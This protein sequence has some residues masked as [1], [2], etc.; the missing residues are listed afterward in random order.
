MLEVSY[1]KGDLEVVCNVNINLLFYKKLKFFDDW[2][3]IKLI[4][5]IC[6]LVYMFI[7]IEYMLKLVYVYVSL[8]FW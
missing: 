5:S 2:I 1:V 3:S 7:F 8:F 4:N 6:V